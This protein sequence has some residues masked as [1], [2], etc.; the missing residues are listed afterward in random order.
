VATSARQAAVLAYAA[1]VR[2]GNPLSARALERQFGISRSEAAKVRA[3]VAAMANCSAEV[4]ATE[5]SGQS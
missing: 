3:E 5:G 4:S 2:G 1:S